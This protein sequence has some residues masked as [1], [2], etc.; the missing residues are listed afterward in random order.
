MCLYRHLWIFAILSWSRFSFTFVTL[1]VGICTNFEFFYCLLDSFLIRYLKKI[2]KSNRCAELFHLSIA[3]ETFKMFLHVGECLAGT[4]C[5]LWYYT[6]DVALTDLWILFTAGKYIKFAME[7]TLTIP[8]TLLSMLL[9][10]TGNP[11]IWICGKC[12]GKCIDLYVHPF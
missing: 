4:F 12:G 11:K 7:L 10:Y 2:G 8:V 3:I 6:M 5:C 9:H 1:I